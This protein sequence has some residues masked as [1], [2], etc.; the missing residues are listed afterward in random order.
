M[1][2]W[3]PQIRSG[4]PPATPRRFSPSLSEVEPWR[5]PLS[6]ALKRTRTAERAESAAPRQEGQPGAGRMSRHIRNPEQT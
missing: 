6:P 2:V 3:G 4:C 5:E 1:G